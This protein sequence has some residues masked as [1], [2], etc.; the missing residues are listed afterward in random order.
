MSRQ[1]ENN[2]EANGV[3]GMK[4]VPGLP[5]WMIGVCPVSPFVIGVV[6]LVDCGAAGSGKMYLYAV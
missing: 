2:G 5:E 1:L 6:L 3:A 4:G